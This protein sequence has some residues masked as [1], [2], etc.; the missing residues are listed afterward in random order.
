MSGDSTG[1]LTGGTIDIINTTQVVPSPHI[2]MLVRDYEYNPTTSFLTG[3]WEDFSTFNIF[4]LDRGDPWA[5]VI[6]NITFTIVPE[7]ASLILLGLGGAALVR[8]NRRQ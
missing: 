3:T 5:P 7:P 6:N 1:T 2:E 8:R 4:L